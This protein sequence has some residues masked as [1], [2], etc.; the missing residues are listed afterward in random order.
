MATTTE[1]QTEMNIVTKVAINVRKR[2]I[3]FAS[4]VLVN[5]LT[6]VWE[7]G[8]TLDDVLAIISDQWNDLQS[9]RENKKDC[10]NGAQFRFGLP[11]EA[12]T[13]TVNAVKGETGSEFVRNYFGTHATGK[14]R[15]TQ[16]HRKPK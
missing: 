10:V 4:G 1:K 14:K 15:S 7:H 2:D 6:L 16:F 3:T 11:V 9:I 8:Y 12:T 13:E 5:V